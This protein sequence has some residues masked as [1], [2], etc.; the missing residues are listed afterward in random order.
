MITVAVT[1]ALRRDAVPRSI[2]RAA[3]LHVCLRHRVRS[4]EFSFVFVDG[5]TIRSINR[6][7]LS[8]DSVTDIITFPLEQKPLSAEIYICLPQMK[9][10]ARQ[11]GVT[12]RNEL[13]RLVVHGT[14]H[15][16][17][18]DDRAVRARKEMTALQERYVKELSSRY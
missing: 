7:F 9:R 17:G 15:A 2:V 11:F 5:R 13:L 14:L 3:V 16:L 6:R 1:D 10:Q 12:E 8:H 4:A 18:Y